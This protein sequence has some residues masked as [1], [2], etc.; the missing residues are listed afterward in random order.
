MQE[1]KVPFAAL[2]AIFNSEQLAER[3]RSDSPAAADAAMQ[4]AQRIR[5]Q[6]GVVGD[7]RKLLREG[8]AEQDV[9]PVA[10][11]AV[12]IANAYVATCCGSYESSAMGDDFK[13]GYLQGKIIALEWIVG[14]AKSSDFSIHHDFESW[15]QAKAGGK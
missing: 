8:V 10:R 15:R 2:M 14:W 9:P 4:T 1:K 12:E 5:K 3:L 7:I 13:H 11:N 6:H